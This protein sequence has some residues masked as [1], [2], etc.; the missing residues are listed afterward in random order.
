MTLNGLVELVDFVSRV[1]SL[2]VIP[3]L[4]AAFCLLVTHLKQG[5]VTRV[6]ASELLEASEQIRAGRIRLGGEPIA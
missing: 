5:A 6:R 2:E 1:A 4:T 3:L